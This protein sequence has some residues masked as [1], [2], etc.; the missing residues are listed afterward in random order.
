VGEFNDQ[1]RM[2]DEWAPYYDS[3]G[4]ATHWDASEAAAFL[5]AC[6][7]SGPAL[8]LGVGTGRVA[9]PLAARVGV[10]GVDA[11]PRMLDALERK[12]GDLPIRT[13]CTDMAEPRIDAGPFPLIYTAAG[14]LFCLLTAQ[15]QKQCF[16]RVAAL[17][18]P[19]GC[20]VVEAAHPS[21]YI[22][23]PGQVTVRDTGED[24]LRIGSRRHDPATQTVHFH[25]VHLTHEGPD[26]AGGHAIQC[27]R[28][29][30]HSANR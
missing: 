11:S 9:L 3:P 5:A 21:H 30:G 26:P 19:G 13:V 29:D 18:A 8:E 1:A 17:L 28:G 25:E 6:A 22:G 2:W 23:A 7:Q 15:R 16:A 10:T 27:T 12:R 24:Y 4:A 14:T 20:F